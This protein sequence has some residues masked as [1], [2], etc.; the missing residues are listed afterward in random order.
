MGPM[1]HLAKDKPPARAVAA[2]LDKHVDAA[3]DILERPRL[4][5]EHVHEARKRL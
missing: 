2:D 1:S 4:T 3:L 5:D